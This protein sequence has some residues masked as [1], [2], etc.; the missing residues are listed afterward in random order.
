MWKEDKER[1][2]EMAAPVAERGP[3]HPTLLTELGVLVAGMTKRELFAAMAMQGILTD[4]ANM[5]VGKHP[6]RQAVEYADALLA[7]LDK[8]CD[9]TDVEETNVGKF[10][11]KCGKQITKSVQIGEHCHTVLVPSKETFGCAPDEA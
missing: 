7:E 3:V 6:S 1:L 10:C 11:K 2:I 4:R 9:H 5:V 8:I